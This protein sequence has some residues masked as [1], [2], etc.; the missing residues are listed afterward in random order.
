M[1]AVPT[2]RKASLR[3]SPNQRERPH[4]CRT[5]PIHT[6][7]LALNREVLKIICV[8][9]HPLTIFIIHTNTYLLTDL[10][11]VPLVYDNCRLI[12]MYS[13]AFKSIKVHASV[14]RCIK[15]YKLYQLSMCIGVYQVH[16]MPHVYLSVL[17]CI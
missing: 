14:F 2:N 17:R 7:P 9:I 4:F 15:V 12:W 16:E 6:L 13:G 11:W 10:V 3:V 8:G 5:S 1:A